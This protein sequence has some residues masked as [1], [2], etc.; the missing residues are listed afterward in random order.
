MLNK[1]YRI[2][3]A[4]LH[5]LSNLH[6][7][8]HIDNESSADHKVLWAHKQ[9]PCFL[10]GKFKCNGAL[11]LRMAFD[12]LELSIHPTFYEVKARCFDYR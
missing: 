7:V 9:T 8:S 12:I 6:E 4:C 2:N 3:F 11:S 10:G 1:N 5:Q